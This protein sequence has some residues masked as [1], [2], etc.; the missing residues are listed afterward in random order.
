MTLLNILGQYSSPQ[1]FLGCRTQWSTNFQ[2]QTFPQ[3]WLTEQRR[4]AEINFPTLTSTKVGG[5]TSRSNIYATS[6]IISTLSKIGAIL[7]KVS[8]KY[9]TSFFDIYPCRT[10]L[11][12]ILMYIYEIFINKFKNYYNK[13]AKSYLLIFTN[14]KWKNRDFSYFK[15]E[16][17]DC[18]IINIIQN[19]KTTLYTL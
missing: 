9:S 6:L 10:L 3:G 17:W 18:P 5:I 13:L 11:Y 15:T 14:S 7:A 19:P 12:M 16:F 8:N 4:R 1:G 2:D